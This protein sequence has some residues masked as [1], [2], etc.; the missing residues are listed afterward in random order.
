LEQQFSGCLIGRDYPF[1][2]VDHP[3]AY[4]MAQEKMHHLR[5]RDDSKREARMIQKKHG[6]RKQGSKRWR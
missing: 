6:S 2:I 3:T 1:P 4:R 5:Q